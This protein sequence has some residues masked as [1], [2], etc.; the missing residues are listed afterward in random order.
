MLKIAFRN[1][2]RNGRR[3]LMTASAIAVGAAALI[4]LGEYNGMAMVGMQ[5][6]IIRS[7]GHLTLF[8]TGYFEFGSAQPMAYGIG[9][10]PKIIAAIKADPQVKDKLRVVTP[11]VTLGG[12]A[13]NTTV[14]R[15]KTFFGQGFVPSDRDKMQSWDEYRLSPHGRYDTTGLKDADID[16]GVVGQ[17]LARILGLCQPLKVKHCPKSAELDSAMAGKTPEL[18]LLSGASGAPNIV[19]FHPTE[20]QGMGAKELEDSYIAMNLPLA[21]QLLYGGGEKKV[22]AIVVQL[23]R[24]ED[25]A[26]VRARLNAL[27]TEKHFDLEIRDYKEVQPS[28]LQIMGFLQVVFAFL[29]VVLGIIV[30]F[31]TANTMGMSIM[32][33]TAEIGTARAMGVRR[34]GIRSQFLLEGAILGVFGATGGLLLGRIATYF[35]NRADIQYTPPGNSS[36]VQ[37]YLL[38]HGMEGL[39][40]TIWIV[41]VIMATLASIVPANRAARMN[42]VDALRHV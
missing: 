9:D 6:G 29:T 25:M 5:T 14:D 16:R 15:S 20:A 23:N 40:A 8:K 21:Q 31:T 10:Y 36:P 13:G 19:N 17:G 39:M 24:S 32:E 37:L 1:V 27:V 7:A 28:F 26:A 3:S 34:G 35:I 18:Q 11:T 41:L 42:V 2:L 30:L 33:R 12:I 38:A 4:L 22:T